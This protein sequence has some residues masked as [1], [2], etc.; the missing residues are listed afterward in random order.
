MA[1]ENRASAS[2]MAAFQARTI[3]VADGTSGRVAIPFAFRSCQTQPNRSSAIGP[4]FFGAIGLKMPEPARHGI[5]FLTEGWR[6]CR[7][8]GLTGT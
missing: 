6:L 5:E 4:D 8:R 1:M 3:P 2:V 7:D